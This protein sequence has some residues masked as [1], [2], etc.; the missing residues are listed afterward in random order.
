MPSPHLLLLLFRPVDRP[1]NERRARVGGACPSSGT[2][3]TQIKPRWS[4]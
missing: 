2:Q 3:M 1:S 4:I